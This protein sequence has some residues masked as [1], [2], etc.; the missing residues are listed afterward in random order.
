MF[1]STCP[2]AAFCTEQGTRAELVQSGIQP[3]VTWE[4]R[5]VPYLREQGGT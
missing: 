5:P 4:R 1:H 2:L 3:A